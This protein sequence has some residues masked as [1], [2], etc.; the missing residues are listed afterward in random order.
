MAIIKFADT[1]PGFDGDKAE[2]LFRPFFTTKS[3][4]NGTGLGLAICA[5]LVKKHKGRI[6]A[7]NNTGKGS[8]FTVYLPL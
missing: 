6:T 7:E 8:T 3:R 5:D 2:D 1:G 4:G